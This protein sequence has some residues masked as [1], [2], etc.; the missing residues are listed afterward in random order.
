MNL[1]QS[2][3]SEEEVTE[4]TRLMAESLAMENRGYNTDGG[5]SSPV[6][7]SRRGSSRHS[8]SSQPAVIVP[9]T[10]TVSL[11]HFIRF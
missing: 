4:N 5:H 8:D 10:E 7:G 2:T 9:S 1:E 6:G 3:D 11:L